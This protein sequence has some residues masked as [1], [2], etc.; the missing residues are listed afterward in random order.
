MPDYLDNDRDNDGLPDS[1]ERNVTKTDPADN[2]SESPLTNYTEADNDVI[3]GMEDFDQD[4]LG[5]TSSTPSAR[6]RS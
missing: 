1:Y 6:T 4:T 5:H 2:D 3:D